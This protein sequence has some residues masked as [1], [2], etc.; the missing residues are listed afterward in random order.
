MAQPKVTDDKKEKKTKQNNGQNRS[1]R[2]LGKRGRLVQFW[3]YK[4]K[5]VGKSV[6]RI[7]KN[8]QLIN[9]VIVGKSMICIL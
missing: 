5:F 6:I 7:K 1:T 9:V 3:T 2:D 8:K 4:A